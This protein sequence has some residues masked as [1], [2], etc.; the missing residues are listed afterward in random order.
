M[1]FTT[2]GPHRR[3]YS[4]WPVSRL[5]M[6]NN[7]RTDEFLGAIPQ[8]QLLGRSYCA[9]EPAT[10]GRFQ[11]GPV[12]QDIWVGPGQGEFPVPAVLVEMQTG[13]PGAA[14]S[15]TARSLVAHGECLL[16]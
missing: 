9:A 16:G 7:M 10:A 4:L 13:R 12:V 5:G 6:A 15:S 8:Q 11:A 3:T 14:G 2:P 1:G